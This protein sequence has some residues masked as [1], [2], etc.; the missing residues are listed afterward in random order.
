MDY[1]G[2]ALIGVEGQSPIGVNLLTDWVAD[3]GFSFSPGM[4]ETSVHIGAGSQES[5][6]S[7]A[8]DDREQQHAAIEVPHPPQRRHVG[9][10]EQVLRG[11]IPGTPG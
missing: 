3:V 9:G 5:I 6:E 10:I 2:P 1:Q 7:E 8:A 4:S 11:K